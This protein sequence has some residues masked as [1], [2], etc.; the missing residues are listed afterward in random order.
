MNHSLPKSADSSLIFSANGQV[1][2]SLAA[3][4]SSCRRPHTLFQGSSLIRL[5]NS[6]LNVFCK[7]VKPQKP[8]LV[9]TT[10]F[11]FTSGIYFFTQPI[12][13][14]FSLKQ[15]TVHTCHSQNR[16]FDAFRCFAAS[17]AH[18]S[19]LTSS[20]IRICKSLLQFC[21][22]LCQ[23]FLSSSNLHI[24]HNTLEVDRRV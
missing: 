11:K 22:L 23:L 14:S 18:E 21:S 15:T 2:F 1:E 12:F 24:P 17:Y 20:S 7:S 10:E 8:N 13:P 16:F 5:L 9:F 6:T 3:P 4:Y 19:A